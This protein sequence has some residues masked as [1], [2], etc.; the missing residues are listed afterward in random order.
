MVGYSRLRRVVP[1][2]RLFP[3][4]CW[5]IPEPPCGYSLPVSLLVRYSRLLPSPV[6]L[7]DIVPPAP[8]T[9]FTVGHS[10]G[11]WPPVPLK[12]VKVRNVGR[13]N[14]AG[15]NNQEC[16]GMRRTQ[17]W[18]GARNTSFTPRINHQPPRNRAGTAQKPATERTFAQGETESQT[19]LFSD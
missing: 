4:H 17:G 18:A 16:C 7:L 5:L 14:S 1:L 19:L 11:P 2:L 3:F 13:T 9:L 10:P 15:I 8:I 12:V 6:S